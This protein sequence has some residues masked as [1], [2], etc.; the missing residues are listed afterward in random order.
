[1]SGG[2]FP[3]PYTVEHIARRKHADVE[4]GRQDG[5]ETANLFI[6]TVREDFKC[7]MLIS[8][9]LLP[10]GGGLGQSIALRHFFC[11]SN[12]WIFR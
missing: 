4:V 3:L 2:K 12:L 9:G 8:N 5:V 11:V 1:M 7:P 6:P 10:K